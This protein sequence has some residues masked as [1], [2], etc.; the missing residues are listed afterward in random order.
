MQLEKFAKQAV[1]LAARLRLDDIEILLTHS[2]TLSAKIENKDV[3]LELKQDIF[4]AGVRVIRKGRLGYVPMTEPS[5]DL[6]KTGI[7]AALER[8]G[9]APFE[10]FAVIKPGPQ[11]VKTHDPKVA[12]MLERPLTV[13]NLA[14][15]IISQTFKVKGVENIE[16]AIN[17]SIEDRLVATMHSP[18]PALAQRT[19]FSAF[20]DVNSRD[21]DFAA[22]RSLPDLKKVARLGRNLARSLP[23]KSTT[24]EKEKVKGKKVLVII[25]PVMLETMLRKLIVEHIYAST[26]QDRMSRYTVGDRVAARTVTLWDDGTAPYSE[27]TF[28]TDDEGTPT[29]RTKVIENGTLL[30]LLYDRAS[31]VKDG[32]ESTG[33]GRRR[34]VLI[35][36]EHEAPVRC[37]ASDL[38]LAPGK[39]QL[40]RMVKDIKHGVLV[41]YLLGFHTAN[42]TT[43]DFTNALYVGR[44]IRN[45]RLAALPEPGRWALKGNALDCLKDITAISRETFDTGSGVLPW[46]QVELTVA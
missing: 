40:S 46:V 25:H 7:K 45:G 20:V 30:T 24:P 31:A 43:G 37:T 39:T 29:R 3:N 18:A 4:N 34:P 19:M 26:V 15:D 13:K 36:D 42:K 14:Q 10:S 9:A 21:F 11:K 41:K 27:S 33:N 6:L 23:G 17:L 5:L 28:P 38:F 2:R 1:R 44:I 22:S 32:V 35:E 8:A 16:G 12:R